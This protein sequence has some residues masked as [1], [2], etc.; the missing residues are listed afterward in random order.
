MLHEEKSAETGELRYI[1]VANPT[2]A[3]EASIAGGTVPMQEEEEERPSAAETQAEEAIKASAAQ[4]PLIYPVFAHTWT[5]TLFL[6]PLLRNPLFNVA[7]SASAESYALGM[8][9][10]AKSM[11]LQSALTTPLL[12]PPPQTKHR[13]PTATTDHGYFAAQKSTT[14]LRYFKPSHRTTSARRSSRF[15]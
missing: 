4:Q 11:P 13:F 15:F 3:K 8:L 12:P 9:K 2:A 14:C 10:T 7:S 1:V 5:Y 6:R